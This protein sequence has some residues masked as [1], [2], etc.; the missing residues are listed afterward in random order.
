MDYVL[1]FNY[2]CSLNEEIYDNYGNVSHVRI[3]DKNFVNDKSLSPSKIIKN[4]SN[5][6]IGKSFCIKESNQVINIGKDF[7]GEY[8]YSKSTCSLSKGRKI[9]KSKILNNIDEIILNAKNR[10]YSSNK[11]TK[12]VKDGKYGFYKYDT[13]FSINKLNEEKF[14]TGKIVIRNDIN[15]K[16]YLYDIISIKEKIN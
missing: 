13:L 2:N 1:D 15:G 6:Y 3:D 8:A 12:H 9:L 16:K 11:K 10:N 5:N 14:Y 7:P 4:V